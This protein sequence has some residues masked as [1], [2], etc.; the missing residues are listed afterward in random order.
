MIDCKNCGEQMDGNGY[1]RVI[2]CPNANVEKYDYHEPD[3]EP[4]F[5]DEEV[6]DGQ[7]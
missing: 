4:V 6:D 3:A 2:H 1:S 5:C 7:K